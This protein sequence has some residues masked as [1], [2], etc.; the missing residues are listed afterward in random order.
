MKKTLLFIGLF[1]SVFCI[2]S[3]QREYTC[4]C[5]NNL[6]GTQNQTKITAQSQ[7][8]AQTQCKKNEGYVTTCTIQ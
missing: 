5:T 4:T 1:C 6:L 8:E 3:C 2:T 7:D